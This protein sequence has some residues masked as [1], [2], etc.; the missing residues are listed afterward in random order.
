MLTILEAINRSAEYLG[1]KG[2]DNPRSNAEQLLCSILHCKRLNLYL[3]FER[4]LSDDE[5]IKYREVLKRRGER[6]PLQYI[7]GTVEF[8]G[9]E[10]T[11][12]KSVLIP[13]PETE[14]LVEKV[15]NDN[16]NK[17]IKVLDIGTGS[18]NIAITIKHHLP[19][20]EVSA[21][22]KS[23]EALKIAELNAKKNNCMIRFIEADI[24]SEETANLDKFDIIVSNPPYV[25]EED[26]VNLEPELKVYE[27]K[28]ALSDLSDGLSFYRRIINISNLL[29]NRE[30][31]IYLEMGAEQS[32]GIKDMMKDN[33]TDVSIIKDYQ[34]IDRVI[35]GVRS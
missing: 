33:F 30:G 24:M 28:M 5:T 14:F 34:M 16:K 31:K 17:E 21:L 32:S 26:F 27:P 8:Y 13:R 7:I 23:K 29:L 22:D 4:P 20:A 10:F 11:V 35:S 25:S 15:I 18:G 2:V 12:D 3:N 19:S 1:K 9:L 6:E